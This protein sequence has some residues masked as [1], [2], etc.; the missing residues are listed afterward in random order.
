MYILKWNFQMTIT[1][2]L[3]ADLIVQKA[4]EFLLLSG[5]KMIPDE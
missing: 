1:W 5:E 2:M 3:Q 4:A